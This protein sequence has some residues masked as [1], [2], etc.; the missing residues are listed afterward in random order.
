MCIRDSGDANLDGQVAFNDFI[1]L[2]QNFGTGREWWQGNFDGSL[3]GVQFG[4]F[5]SLAGNFGASA[6]AATATESF[7]V[8]EPTAETLLLF[9]LIALPLVA[10]RA[11]ASC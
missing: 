4:D 5:V 7:S 11:K 6:A 2:A 3:D 10:R 9:A 1:T 8:P